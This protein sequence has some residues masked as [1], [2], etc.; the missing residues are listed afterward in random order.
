MRLPAATLRVLDELGLLDAFLE[1]PHQKMRQVSLVVGDK[2][3]TMA[4]LFGLPER[5]AFIAFMPQWEFLDFLVGAAEAQSTFTRR[6]RA[7]V[8]GL[9]WDSG[10]RVVGIRA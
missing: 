2:R 3:V 4:D 8:I 5:Y 10:D 1:R 6:R 7:E 9:K